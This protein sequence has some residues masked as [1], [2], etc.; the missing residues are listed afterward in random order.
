MFD[1]QAA[2]LLLLLLLL[3]AGCASAQPRHLGHSRH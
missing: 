3:L 1:E 2:L